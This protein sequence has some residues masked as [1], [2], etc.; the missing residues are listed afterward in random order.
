MEKTQ[1]YRSRKRRRVALVVVID[2]LLTAACFLLSNEPLD[3][4]LG[5]D[6]GVRPRRLWFYLGLFAVCASRA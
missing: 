6:P 2:V 5:E 4:K 3:L 1:A